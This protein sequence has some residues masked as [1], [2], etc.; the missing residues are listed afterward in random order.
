MQNHLPIK[1]SM[2]IKISHGS[3]P[4]QQ[5]ALHSKSHLVLQKPQDDSDSEDAD[6][7]D[8]D[9]MRRSH[10][11]E[12]K[13]MAKVS[14]I[15]YNDDAFQVGNAASY[16]R[17]SQGLTGATGLVRNMNMIGLSPKAGHQFDAEGQKNRNINIDELKDLLL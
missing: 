6:S 15:N 17:P 9:R 2:N 7:Q 10:P 16:G 3:T 11:G 4:N 5:M 12:P 1:Q 13:F 8:S 14:Q